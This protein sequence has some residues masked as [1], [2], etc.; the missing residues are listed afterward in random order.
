MQRITYKF[1]IKLKTFLSNNQITNYNSNKE[2]VY[3]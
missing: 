3:E 1:D 2:I